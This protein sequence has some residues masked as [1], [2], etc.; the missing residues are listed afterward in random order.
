MDC[1]NNR[2]KNALD[3]ILCSTDTL[4]LVVPQCHFANYVCLKP[5]EEKNEEDRSKIDDLCGSPM[6]VRNLA[7]TSWLKDL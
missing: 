7:G 3:S 6:S 1:S 5:Q 4:F 2:H